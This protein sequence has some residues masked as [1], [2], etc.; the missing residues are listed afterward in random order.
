MG[1]GDYVHIKGDNYG[2]KLRL[3]SRLTV[4]QKK[5]GFEMAVDQ[6]SIMLDNS[7]I[8]LIQG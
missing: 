7:T 3:H 5:K 8:F 6:V 2:K 1:G 4:S